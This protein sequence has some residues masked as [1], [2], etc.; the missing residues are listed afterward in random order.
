MSAPAAARNEA[1]PRGAV[2][3]RLAPVAARMV[4]FGTGQVGSALLQ[5][6][7]RV[8]PR[9]PEA[10]ALQLVGVANTRR[11]IASRAALDPAGVLAQLSLAGACAT[12]AEAVLGALGDEGPRIAIDASGSEGLAACHADWLARGIHVVSANK[13]GQGGPLSR[14]RAIRTAAAQSGARYGDAAT[15]GA[16]LPLLRT[17]RALLA[18]GD[19]IEAIAG[20]L[21]GSLAWLCANHDGVR[22]F[23]ARLREAR[24]LGYTEPDPRED[25]SGA[26][27]RR[28]LLILARSAGHA[29]E[30]SAVEVQSLVP[31]PLAELP[32]VESE[33]AYGM[34]DAPLRL[35]LHEA[36]QTGRRLRY[37][38]RFEPG[39]ARVGLEALDTAD[40]L[41]AGGG[42]DNRVAFW[43]E[44]YS[45]RP[46]LIQGPGAGAAVTAAALL[47][48]V[49]QCLADGGR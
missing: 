10:A 2:L 27:V 8:A 4:L 21:S 31:A 20:V 19:R 7:V 15:V 32:L 39:R 18:G 41:A 25:L 14:W 46:L 35:R 42:C 26:D 11:R 16:G 22:P 34:L 5:R 33:Q 13:L 12:D 28:K 48:D 29:L 36:Q 9:T 1:A 3:P 45:E 23:S 17:L 37:V 49:L 38:A 47:D 6:I 40:P 24:A 44:R 30:E 43:S